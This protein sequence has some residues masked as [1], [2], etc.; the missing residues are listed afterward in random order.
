MKIRQVI[1][2]IIFMVAL[3]VFLVVCILLDIQEYL[4]KLPYVTLLVFYFIGKWARNYEL[5]RLNKSR[6]GIEK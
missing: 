6:E 5:K 4:F 3:A 1:V 2:D